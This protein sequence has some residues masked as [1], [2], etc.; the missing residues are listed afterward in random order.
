[1]NYL[2]D[3]ELAC[4]LVNSFITFW[5]YSFGPEESKRNMFALAMGVASQP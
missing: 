3:F 4:D 1:M 2:T 5:L